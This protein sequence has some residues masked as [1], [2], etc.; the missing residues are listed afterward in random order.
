MVRV[1]PHHDAAT[2]RYTL[3]LEQDCP[4]TPGQQD[5]EP[6]HIPIALA[7]LDPDT[8]EPLA[9]TGSGGA[10]DGG[11]AHL[12]SRRSELVF[13]D[14]A[15]RPVLS[16]GRGF[17][18]PVKLQVQREAD[19]LAFLMGHDDDPFNRWDAAQSL[20]LKQLLELAAAPGNAALPESFVRAFGHT[21][22][23]TRGDRAL[24]AEA[25]SLPS[26][27]YVAD[28]L[29]RVDPEAIHAA[30]Q[31]IRREL[32]SRLRE[33]FQR[34]MAQN[35][36][37]T[38]YRFEPDAVGRRALKNLCLGY[39][40]ELDDAEVRR[41]C[42]SQLENA[43]NMTDQLAAL[44][45][46]ANTDVPER[47]E[48]L[49]L[50]EQRWRDDPLVLDKWFTAQAT[51]C[52][53][54]TLQQ[55]R[56]LASHPGFDPHNPNRVRSL[57]GAFCHGNQLRF[58]AA[59]GSGYRF[60]AEQVIAIDP[61]NPQIAARLL[62]AFSRWRRFDEARQNLMQTELEGVLAAPGLSKDCYEVASKTLA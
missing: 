32:A 18:A 15:R 24:I 25:L 1:Q 44:Y 7:L 3:V 39:L 29:D 55:V 46:L 22:E 30:R 58:H 21:L 16:I 56:E 54:D 12:T 28:Q 45:M 37:N 11:V 43:D 5:K 62:G 42:M 33:Q 34:T 61:A 31:L 2:G 27:S 8:G 57:V 10:L 9:T 26:E 52:L 6:F 23:D 51:A 48:A 13:D 17:S 38:P 59:D 53:P 41:T 19:E 60:A 14:V 47:G 49:A 4:P 36:S 35:Q 40:M 20:A 50:F